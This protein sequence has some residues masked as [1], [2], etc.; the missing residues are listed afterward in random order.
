ME[1]L[2]HGKIKYVGKDEGNVRNVKLKNLIQA[3]RTGI[4]EA[5]I[6]PK[7]FRTIMRLNLHDKRVPVT[8]AWRVLRLGVGVEVPASNM[9]GSC[10]IY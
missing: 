4:S 3:V 8:T 2:R 7:I 9:E 6:G 10:E 1:N 5:S